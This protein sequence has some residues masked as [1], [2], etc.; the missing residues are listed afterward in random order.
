VSSN[1]VACLG[2]AGS[3]F[4]RAVANVSSHRYNGDRT[5]DSEIKKYIKESLKTLETQVDTI[6]KRLE[7]C[8]AS[9]TENAR[10]VEILD[11][12]KGVGPVTVSTI[13]AELPELGELTGAQIA[14]LVGVAPMNHDSG[15]KTGRRRTFG[16]RSNMRRV[17]YM[18]TLV[19]TRYN[20]AIKAFYRRLVDA[21]KPK[22]VALTAMRKLLTIIKKDEL[23]QDRATKTST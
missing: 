3:V 19:A 1:P 23:W 4:A 10:N 12:V 16:S 8:V 22:K 9:D 7:K 15:Q 14:K 20:D 6:N 18:A 13:L 2:V 11:S 5:S 17:L 21:G